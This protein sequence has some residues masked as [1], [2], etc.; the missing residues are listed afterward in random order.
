MKHL[1]NREEE[2]IELFL[3][4]ESVFVKELIGELADPEPH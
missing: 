3:K 1:T 4:K 2:I